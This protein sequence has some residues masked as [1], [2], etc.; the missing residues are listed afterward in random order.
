MADDRVLTAIGGPGVVAIFRTP[1][2]D[3][4]LEACTALRDNG[5]RAVEITMTIPG[6]LGLIETV[7]D[8][9]GGR[10]GRRGGHGPRR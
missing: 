10:S 4:V 1:S 2:R 8:A 5:I 3:G 6:A 9:L 7:A